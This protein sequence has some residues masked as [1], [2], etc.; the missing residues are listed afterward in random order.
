MELSFFN[1]RKT[2]RQYSTE[3]IS[4]KFLNEMIELASHAPTTGNMQLYSV[5]CTREQALKEKLAP[6][7]FNQPMATSAPLVL[8][9]CADFNRFVKWC[10]ISDAIPGYDNFQ[11]LLSSILDVTIFAQQFVTIAEM[12]GIGCCYLGTTTYNPRQISEILN[13]PKRVI[14]IIT[15]T[16]GW[17]DKDN[18]AEISDRLP[19]K[20]IIHQEKYNDY[21]PEDIRELYNHKDTLQANDVFIREN[22]KKTLAQVFTDVRYT[23]ANNEFFS[24]E[25]IDFAKNQLFDLPE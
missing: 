9:F 16:L 11:S 13:I 23:K 12:R 20:G 6:A 1:K 17:P 25:F 7:H 22:G 2:I 24:K 5:I 4:E 15:I 21:S 14:P 8:T 3:P 19:I 10:E 18:T